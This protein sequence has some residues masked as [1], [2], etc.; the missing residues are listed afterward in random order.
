MIDVEKLVDVEQLWQLARKG[1]GRG[2]K[3]AILDTGVDA[4]HPA[5]HDAVKS[6]N[7]IAAKGRNLTCRACED[8][9]AVGHGTACAGII[10]RRR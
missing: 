8:G 2:V 3:V 10:H 1:T 9:D 7:E 6:Q 4:G 5:L